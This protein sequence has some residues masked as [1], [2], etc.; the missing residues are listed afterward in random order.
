MKKVFSKIGLLMILVFSFLISFFEQSIPIQAA[1]VI[2][3]QDVVNVTSI[4]KDGNNIVFTTKEKYSVIELTYEICYW[5]QGIKEGDLIT[6]KEFKKIDDYTYSFGISNSIIG[7]KIH[8]IRYIAT[9]EDHTPS[10]NATGS[11]TWG[12]VDSSRKKNYIEVTTD[13]LASS[14][15]CQAVNNFGELFGSNEQCATVYVFYFNLDTE[16]DEIIDI[17]F[18]YAIKVVEKKLFGKEKEYTKT[19][20]EVKVDH[21]E[22][23]W[24]LNGF[25][26]LIDDLGGVDEVSKLYNSLGKE[27]YH[28]YLYEHGYIRPALGVNT[29]NNEYD[30]YLSPLTNEEIALEESE[31]FWGA[32]YY[33]ELLQEVG[34]IK[35]SY[36]SHGEYFEDIPVKD[37]DTGWVKYE[38][39]KETVWDKILAFLEKIYK[40]CGESILITAGVIILIIC[41]IV[42]LIKIGIKKI[43]LGLY[44]L[45]EKLVIFII[46]LLKWIICLP[47]KLIRKLFKKKE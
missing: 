47:F 40:L 36:Y 13:E 5:N 3:K 12:D 27:A 44:Y 37:E 22:L 17:T 7:V 1:N 10:K 9:S 31:D 6:T 33:K 45:I 30:W 42:A 32:S 8:E 46:T 4:F 15:T 25:N 21:N 14:T 20:L 28:N 26:D 35:M 39:K 41:I 18:E 29:D 19:N 11:I 34:L 24:R 43:I 2:T 16:I 38:H 23:T